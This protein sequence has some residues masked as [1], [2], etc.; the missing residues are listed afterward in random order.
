MQG[1][2]PTSDIHL[3]NEEFADPVSTTTGMDFKTRR[4]TP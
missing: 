2:P 3:S 1:L 4:T